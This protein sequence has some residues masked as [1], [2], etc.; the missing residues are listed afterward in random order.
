MET[1][2][3]ETLVSLHQLRRAYYPVFSGL[4][5]ILSFS[6][7]VAFVFLYYNIHL[8]SYSIP[9]LSAYLYELT[10]NETYH[11]SATLSHSFVQLHL[12]NA[13]LG[14]FV[15]NY[16]LLQCRPSNDWA[17][18]YDTGLYLE[19]LTVLAHA[20]NDPQLVQLCVGIPVFMSKII[21]TTLHMQC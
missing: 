1:L 6:G 21:S 4:R 7:Y 3:R 12:Y 18:T 15:D 8:C 5:L 20:T 2:I 10:K 19:G 9:R 17:F 11:T 14:I 13:S 16:D